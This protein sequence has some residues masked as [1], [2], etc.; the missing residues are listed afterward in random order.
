MSGIDLKFK[1]K[2]ERD[3]FKIQIQMGAGYIS[4]SNFNNIVFECSM[5]EIFQGRICKFVK[6]GVIWCYD[7]LVI[8]C[9]MLF[10]AEIT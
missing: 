6:S 1:F 2:W 9:V 4:N 3:I 5:N 7:F 10:D 8:F